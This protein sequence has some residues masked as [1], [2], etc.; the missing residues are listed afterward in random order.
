L[1]QVLPRS[2]L[3]FSF[4]NL[5][6]WEFIWIFYDRNHFKINISDILN[7]N[8]AKCIPLNPAHQDL[9]NNTKRHIPIP[10]RFSAPIL[11]NI[12]WRNHSLFKNFCTTSPNVMEPSH[13]PLLVESFPKTPRTRSE[14]SGF[15]RSHN[16]EAKQ[17]KTNNF[18]HR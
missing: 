7:P 16:Y 13:A 12:Q 10:P 1:A 8:V 9:S 15:S 4:Q 3:I 6:F 18:L 17:N 2:Q 14:A 11:F 5:V